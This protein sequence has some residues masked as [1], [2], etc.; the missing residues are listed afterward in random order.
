M[1]IVK[2][3]VEYRAALKLSRLSAETTSDGRRFH[4]GTDLP[5]MAYLK[6]LTDG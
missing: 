2:M 6:A 3:A 4:S 5:N 1:G